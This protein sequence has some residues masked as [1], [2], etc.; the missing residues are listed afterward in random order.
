[1]IITTTDF[2]PGMRIKEILDVV[3]GTDIYLVGGMVGGGLANQEKLFGSAFSAARSHMESKAFALG[4]D[5]IVGVK[6]NFTS[7]GGANNMILVL[8]GTAVKLESEVE[9]MQKQKRLE[10]EAII[11]QKAMEEEKKREAERFEKLKKSIKTETGETSIEE[12]IE[13]YNAGAVPRKDI[14]LSA[15]YSFDEPFLLREVF[16]LFMQR[17]PVMEIGGYL[18]KMEDE[19][20]LVKNPETRKYSIVNND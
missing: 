16:S 6:S 8:M 4:A 11:R 9:A 3:T 19:G 18:Q 7:P 15:C 20:I 5:A 1:M 14:I 2:V 13:L 17:I 10:E 12:L